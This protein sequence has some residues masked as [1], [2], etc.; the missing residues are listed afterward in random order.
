MVVTC[1]SC[2]KVSHASMGVLECA[3]NKRTLKD[4]FHSCKMR[5]RVCIC[6]HSILSGLWRTKKNDFTVLLSNAWT[7]SRST[8]LW[9]CL[10]LSESK[11]HNDHQWFWENIQGFLSIFTSSV[12]IIPNSDGM[13][14]LK[15]L[16]HTSDFFQLAT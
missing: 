12:K 11:V 8:G 4:F 13:Q 1:T 5:L 3:K 14:I 10:K 6:C 9:R 7:Y 16:P 2:L 15:T